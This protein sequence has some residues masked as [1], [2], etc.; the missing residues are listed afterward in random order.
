MGAE[1]RTYLNSVGMNSAAR[2][3]TGPESPHK[4]RERGATIIKNIETIH[5]IRISV[6]Y[7]II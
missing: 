4:P 6:L 2:L 7:R 3:P 1:K 5:W